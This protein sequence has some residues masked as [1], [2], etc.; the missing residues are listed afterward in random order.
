M[1]AVI[2]KAMFTGMKM[3]MNV[4]KL[5]KKAIKAS[6]IFEKTLRKEGLPLEMASMLAKTYRESIPIPDKLPVKMFG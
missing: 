2:P 5:R 3:M 1:A 4:A 6:R